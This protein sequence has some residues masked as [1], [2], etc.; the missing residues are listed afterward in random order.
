MGITNSYT[1]TSLSTDKSRNKRKRFLHTASSGG[2]ALFL[3]KLK[4]GFPSIFFVFP[5]KGK[6][7][8]KP[9]R[10]VYSLV[11]NDFFP[12]HVLKNCESPSTTLF[13]LKIVIHIINQLQKIKLSDVYQFFCGILILNVFSP[14]VYQ[15][16]KSLFAK[17]IPN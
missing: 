15:S 12:S 3:Q 1:P 16:Q 5:S 13:G 17:K 10:Q 2:K 9:G 14:R 11:K 7:I 4:L 6:M 8:V